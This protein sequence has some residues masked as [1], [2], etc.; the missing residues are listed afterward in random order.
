MKKILIIL[1]AASVFFPAALIR[2]ETVSNLQELLS[3]TISDLPP[4]LHCFRVSALDKAENESEKSE[5]AC[6]QLYSSTTIFF[7]PKTFTD[8]VV[9]R[10]RYKTYTIYNR[11]DID[12]VCSAPKIRG[13]DTSRVFSTDF[14][15]D[16]R[17]VPEGKVIAFKVFFSPKQIGDHMATLFINCN[18]NEQSP[19]G[20]TLIGRGI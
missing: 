17:I 6:V 16:L 11:G 7:S 12:L 3:V 20:V 15:G 4:G 14:L 5:E 2:A 8:T 13:G 19:I 1:I 10:K 9:G 18:T